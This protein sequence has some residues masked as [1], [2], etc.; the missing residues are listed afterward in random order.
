MRIEWI[1]AVIL[2]L[3]TASALQCYVTNGTLSTPVLTTSNYANI[4]CG[5]YMFTCTSANTFFCTQTDIDASIVKYAYTFLNEASCGQ[6]YAQPSFQSSN[7]CCCLSDGCNGQD[8]N[9]N[10]CSNVFGGLNVRLNIS[11]TSATG[12]KATPEASSYKSSSGVLD[13]F[14]GLELL[15]LIVLVLVIQ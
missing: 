8:M 12:S 13:S 10:G 11:T 3:P 6:M 1:V 15:M 2:A 7:T 5:S 9:P 14:P 4:S